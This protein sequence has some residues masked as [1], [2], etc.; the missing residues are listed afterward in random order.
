MLKKNCFNN[1]NRFNSLTFQKSQFMF[2]QFKTIITKFK[3]PPMIYIK[4]EEYTRYASELYLNEWI[5]PFVD[6]SNWEFY[7][8]SC[9]SRDDTNDKVLRDCIE[10]GRRVGSIFKEPTITPTDHQKKSM[11]LKNTLRSP[12]GKMRDGWSGQSIS[13]DTIHIEGMKL[14]YTN[15]VLFDRH[16]VGGE[17]GAG[18]DVVEQ[19]V[20]KTV[21]IPSG[22]KKEE[23]I[24]EKRLNGHS[25]AVVVYTNPYDNVVDV[26]HHFFSRCLQENAIPYVVTK[27]NLFKWQ[28]PFWDIMLKVFNT[29]Y[30]HRFN[31]VGL[32][33]NTGG[34]LK[35]LHTDDA[36]MKVVG[37]TQG[38]FGMVAHNY[39][40]DV[41]TDEVAQV[42]RS[43]GFLSSVL[44]GRR[45]DGSLIKEFEASHGT[46]TDMWE[47]HL[48]GEEA[49]LNPLGLIDALAGAMN[50]SAV[51][52]GKTDETFKFT[53]ILMKS[54]YKQMTTKGKATR[55]LSG[56]NGLTTEQFVVEVKKRM[57]GQVDPNEEV[58]ET[59]D[60]IQNV[61]YDV[62]MMRQIFN[63]F[64]TNRDGKLSYEDF[65]KGIRKLRIAPLLENSQSAEEREVTPF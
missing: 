38:G 62:E 51:L 1:F 58:A 6:T 55:D 12:N 2:N 14:G 18:Y 29:N 20:L 4:G 37:W 47:A 40:G 30:K 21:F 59:H 25:N 8:L 27:K 64:D 50:H 49:S 11:G 44:N 36:I 65:E 39:D 32:L 22:S 19:G 24:A 54:L 46:V 60:I 57:M 17:Y 61:Q 23:I 26:A 45:E 35:H 63:S 42:H 16:A 31:K 53:N 56:P 33:N 43:P 41:L 3:A 5:R 52:S 13:R 34:E 10:A 28:E 48:R 9:K 7:D 15:P